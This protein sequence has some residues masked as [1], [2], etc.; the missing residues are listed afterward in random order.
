MKTL[1][2][3]TT[4]RLL[5][6]PLTTDD[7]SF[8]L[9]LVNSDGWI[10]FI[11]NRNVNSEADAAAYIQKMIDNPNT[12]YW[13]VKLKDIE[14]AIGVIT[15]IKRDY[16]EHHDIGFAFLPQFANKGYAYEAAHKVLTYLT[17]NEAHTHILATTIPE[18][19]SSIKLLK[20]LGL[21]F[22]R[23]IEVNDEVLEVYEFIASQ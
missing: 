22:Q 6:V 3:W 10:K 1:Q 20:K 21:H 9:E 15:L 5:I 2:S 17:E 12:T 8:I 14:I 11:G 16:S 7:S 23:S 18:N 4:D 13:V 19:D